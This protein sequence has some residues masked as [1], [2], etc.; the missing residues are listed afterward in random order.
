MRKWLSDADVKEANY[1]GMVAGQNGNWCSEFNNSQQGFKT[2]MAEA[3]KQLET[4]FSKLAP[5]AL[6]KGLTLKLTL[7]ADQ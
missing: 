1:S 7:P 4:E 5:P 6:E 2:K 3:L